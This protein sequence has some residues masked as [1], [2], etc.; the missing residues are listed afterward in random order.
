MNASCAGVPRGSAGVGLTPADFLPTA[1]LL[2]KTSLY[3]YASIIPPS[4]QYGTFLFATYQVSAATQLFAEMMYTHFGEQL[5]NFPPLLSFSA[6]ATTPN[7]PFGVNLTVSD[8]ATGLG[9][10]VNDISEDY[11]RPLL[12]IRGALAE[13]WHW[14]VA[15]WESKDRDDYINPYATQNTPAVS[16]ALG[17]GLFN[18]FQD[19]PQASRTVLSSFYSPDISNYSGTMQ[20]VNGFIRGPLAQLGSGA[21]EAVLGAEYERDSLYRYQSNTTLDLHRTNRSAFAEIRIPI[22]SNRAQPA[23]GDILAAQLAARYDDYSD[24]GSRTS[25]QVA[26]EFRPIDTLLMRAVYSTAFMPPGLINLATSLNL[27]YQTVVSDP[28]RGRQS[29]TVTATCCGNENLQPQTGVSKA[30]SIVYSPEALAGLEISRHGLG[31]SPRER[32]VA[33]GR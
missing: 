5:R 10:S 27:N 9:R 29:E 17:S 8:L 23:A 33:A 1:G 20:T 18:P 19:G 30:L 15:A 25:P 3:S 24:F 22:L 4:Q 21:V 26:L 12:G 6:P 11:I 13:K 7:N 28:L 2:N 32:H 16:A 14:E 31:D